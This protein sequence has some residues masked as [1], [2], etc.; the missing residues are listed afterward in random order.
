[1][2]GPTH[3]ITAFF[4]DDD[5]DRVLATLAQVEERSSGAVTSIETLFRTAGE[6]EL[7]GHKNGV[8]AAHIFG[9]EPERFGHIATTGVVH[10][11]VFPRLVNDLQQDTPDLVAVACAQKLLRDGQLI[12]NLIHIE[13][14]DLTGPSGIAEALRR[15]APDHPLLPLCAL[16]RIP[17]P[18]LAARPMRK[19]HAPESV[20]PWIGPVNE[21]WR[22]L[23]LYACRGPRLIELDAPRIIIANE[24]GQ[25]QRCFNEVMKRTRRAEAVLF[26]PLLRALHDEATALAFAGPTRLV[27]QRGDATRVVD[28]MGG[29]LHRAPPS[30]CTLRG[31]IDGRFAVFHGLHRDA[32][33]GLDEETGLWPAWFLAR[34]TGTTIGE[35]SVLDVETGHFLERAPDS[36]PRTFFE[37]DEP[38][39]LHLGERRLPIGGDRPGALAYTHD[40]RFAW[41][42]ESSCSE[43][44]DRT[45]GFPVAIPA[46]V[47]G[48]E[49][50]DALDL[51]TG[52]TIAQEY[53]G[54]YDGGFALAFADGR[55][56]TLD[57]DGN[58]SD[59]LGTSPIALVP[60][61]TAAAFDPAA[62]R[63]ALLV[64]SE[65]VIL[66][67]VARTI[68]ARFPA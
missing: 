21:A 14:G 59:Q 20:D 55:W 19:G 12:D 67:R 27:I 60:A 7:R 11:A 17:V 8:F 25:V 39:D 5:P 57:S 37:N 32:D 62:A 41:V 33:P 3:P 40:L 18:P 34:P 58:L 42:G 4:L 64:E 15:V 45:T 54:A 23:V 50:P 51:A 65:V 49:V 46:D 56:L 52:E 9:P 1:M 38:E 16:T 63:L 24:S 31:V 6:S 68:V 30:G 61:P 48:N 26:P 35:I 43:I 53:E 2:L 66:D 28:I 10:P 29:E 47:Y 13:D 36:V 22:E 44:V